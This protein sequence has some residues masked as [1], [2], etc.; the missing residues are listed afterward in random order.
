VQTLPSLQAVPLG[1]A[2]L[3]QMPLA[4]LQMPA[5]WHWSGETQITGLA[6]MQVPAWHVSVC[7]H[8]LPSLHALPSG[9]TVVEQAPVEGLQKPASWHWSPAAHTTGLAPVQVPAWHVSVCVHA[10]PSLHDVPLA[11]TGF[12]QTPVPGLH[13]PATWH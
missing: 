13:V 3:T 4:G 7:V 8:A 9:E 12:E 5:T 11:A 1:A 10:L 2:G 6:P